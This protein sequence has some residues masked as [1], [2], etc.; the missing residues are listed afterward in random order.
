MGGK[1]SL[2]VLQQ[3]RR[4]EANFTVAEAIDYGQRLIEEEATKGGRLS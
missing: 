3:A 2:T 1:V 4:E